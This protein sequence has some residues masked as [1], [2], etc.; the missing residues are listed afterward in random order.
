MGNLIV[1]LIILMILGLSIFKVIREKQKG[2]KCVGCAHGSDCSSKQAG[3]TSRALKKIANKI[4]ITEV[5]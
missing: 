2:S 4:N 3:P 5:S 1:S